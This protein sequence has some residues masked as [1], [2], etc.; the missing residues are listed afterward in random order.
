MA[1]LFT[2]SITS[3]QTGTYTANPGEVVACDPSGGGFTVTL[4]AANADERAVVIL[5]IT[6]ST[7][8]ITISRAGSDN[9]NGGTTI[10]ITTAHGAYWLIPDGTSN[11]YAIAKV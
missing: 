9:V 3:T 10:T 1:L 11:W 7:N 6:S 2:P 4:P 5:N 8:T